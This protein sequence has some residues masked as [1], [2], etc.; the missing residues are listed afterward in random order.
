MNPYQAPLADMRF[1]LEQVFDAPNTWSQLPEIAEMV[2]MDTANAI[3]E[4]TF[5]S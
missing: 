5:R 4:P 2:D 3:L 1:L